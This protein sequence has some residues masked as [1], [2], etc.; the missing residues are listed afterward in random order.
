MGLNY[1]GTINIPHRIAY[2]II[3]N[4]TNIIIKNEKQSFITSEEIEIIEKPQLKE[5]SMSML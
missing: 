5:L 2:N 1:H 4:L 3:R